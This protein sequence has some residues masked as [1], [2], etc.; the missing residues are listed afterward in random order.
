MCKMEA[1]QSLLLPGAKQLTLNEGET[2]RFVNQA[3]IVTGGASGIGR[4]TVERLAGEGAHV[5][6]FDINE[7]AGFGL[8]KTLQERNCNADYY[9]V[10]VSDKK[11]CS[12]AVKNFAERSD[13]GG[14][15]DGLVNCAV[16]FGSK[17]MDAQQ[18]DWEKS[19]NVNV[20]GYANM[21]QCCFP[22]MKVES[23]PTGAQASPCSRG[24][25]N[26]ASISGHRAQP[27][28][29]TYA[30]TKGAVLALT[31]CM[32]L[33][34]SAHSI[35]VNSVSPA[36]VWS[37]EVCKAAGGDRD[38][39]EPVWG[40]FH[41]PRRMAETSEIASAVA[42][43]LSRDASYITATDLPVDGGYLAMGPEGLG[44]KSTFAGSDY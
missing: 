9:K 36:W 7:S 29:W 25:V 30:A 27:H 33:D 35:R 20:V 14:R 2:R 4:A 16:Y 24:I 12:E 21:V 18:E 40:P 17:A 26:V 31:K 1:S 8:C 38:K 44:E 42:F 39:W 28:R 3:I 11:Q 15:I 37:P 23:V 10:D 13:N 19:L 34:L 22:Y 41:M 32:A 43:L 6:V 5:A